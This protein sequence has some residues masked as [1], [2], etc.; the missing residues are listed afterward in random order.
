MSCYDF[1]EGQLARFS[2]ET[3]NASKALADPATF[4]FAFEKPSGTVT[5]WV[6]GTNLEIVRDSVGKFHV[7]LTMDEPEWWTWRQE[8][9]GVVT[10]SQGKFRVAAA[11]L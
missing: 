8:S 5:T 9:T 11:L 6:F 3:R 4:T 10:A 1:I 2:F 7:D